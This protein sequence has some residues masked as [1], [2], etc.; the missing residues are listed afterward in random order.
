[1]GKIES[2][3]DFMPKTKKVV[4]GDKVL[5]AR[6]LTAAKR[7]ALAELL[8]NEMDLASLFGMVAGDGE[9]KKAATD[10]LRDAG[11]D[12][13]LGMVRKVFGGAMTKVACIA[14]DTPANREN[15]EE[16]GKD[17]EVSTDGSFDRCE[18]M[19]HWVRENITINQEREAF[20]AVL[21]VTDIPGLVKNYLTFIGN[22]TKSIKPVE[23]TKEQP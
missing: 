10:V 15:V 12:G 22:L 21:E 4:V 17:A 8:F 5:T 19:Y 13:V 18:V 1:M 11:I 20:E 3:E 9:E 2:F 23:E 16:V 7:D 6:E 14:L